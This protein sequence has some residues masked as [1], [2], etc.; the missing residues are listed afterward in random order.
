MADSATE[1]NIGYR[2]GDNLKTLA[3]YRSKYTRN[4]NDYGWRVAVRKGLAFLTR[5]IY[6][7]IVYYL[8]KLDLDRTFGLQAED[9]NDQYVFRMLDWKDADGISQ[10][11]EMEEWLKGTLRRRLKNNCQCMALY[12]GDTIVGFNY[13]AVGEG[14]IPLLKLKVITGPTEAWSEQITISKQ[15]RRKGLANKLRQNFYRELKRNGVTALY[16]HRQEFNV[17]SR[18]SAKKF[19]S[20]ILAR[21]N[22]TKMFRYNRLKVRW[23]D[24]ERQKNRSPLT[25]RPNTKDEDLNSISFF[26]NK[27]PLFVV[28]LGDII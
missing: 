14:N 23:E 1:K 4:L 25:I 21:V 6:Q 19:T 10:I 2:S 16:G 3:N 12:D 28:K 24:L 17:A 11:E 7:N 27:P 22:Y 15:Y 13:A 5:P 18:Q 9:E 8:Y 20:H 26:E